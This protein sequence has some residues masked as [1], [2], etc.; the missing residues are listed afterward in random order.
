MIVGILLGLKLK[1]ITIMPF[2]FKITFAEYNE[3]KY[4]EIKKILV[5]ISGPAINLIIMIIAIALKVHKN[6]IYSNL[7]IAIFNLIPIYQLDGGKIL[8]SILKIKL[9]K[10]KVYT[11]INKISN[12]SIII[13]T[14]LSSIMILYLKNIFILFVIIYLWY[15]VIKEN[16]RYKT[17]KRMYEMIENN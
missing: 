10:S 5:A 3:K 17:I 8:E 12:I 11:I 15:M 14:A 7:I 9:E 16:K 4:K 2:G 6:I 13:L 1:K